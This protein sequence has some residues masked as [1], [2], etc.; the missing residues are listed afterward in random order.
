MVDK[1]KLI[2]IK[3]IVKIPFMSSA[4]IVDMMPRE[5][6]GAL[7]TFI[8]SII[9]P[10]IAHAIMTSMLIYKWVIEKDN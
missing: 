3:E 10:V 2:N 9:L 5:V 6:D 1:F 7:L 4:F 8:F